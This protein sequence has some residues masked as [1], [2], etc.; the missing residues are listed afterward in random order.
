M[1]VHQLHRFFTGRFSSVALT[2]ACLTAV[3]AIEIGCT[4]TP[5]VRRVYTKVSPPKPI[6]PPFAAGVPLTEPELNWFVKKAIAWLQRD[7]ESGTG[8]SAAK[9]GFVAGGAIDRSRAIER[10]Q[11]PDGAMV[12]VSIP[13]RIEGTSQ[14]WMIVYLDAHTGEVMSSGARRVELRR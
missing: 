9:A 12:S 4:T 10:I 13:Q 1:S 7:G 5:Q 11:S 3:L 8:D 2:A 14:Y 6:V